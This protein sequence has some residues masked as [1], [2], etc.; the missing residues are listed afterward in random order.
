LS[1]IGGTLQ[2]NADTGPKELRW[3]ALDVGVTVR[4]NDQ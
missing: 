4:L 2:T 3:E 1:T